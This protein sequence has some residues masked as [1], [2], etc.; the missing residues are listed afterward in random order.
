MPLALEDRLAIT[1]L[2]SLHGHI[3]D[4]GSLERL[5][6]LFTADV[7]HDLTE[8]GQGPLVGVEAIREAALALGAANP[9]AHHVTNI[10]IA[11]SADGLIRVRSKGLGVRADGSCGSVT[12]DDIVIHTPD[13]WRICQRRVSARRTPL[14]GVTQP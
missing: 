8:F 2:V 6:E 13:G 4:D 12:Y 11:E 1:E 7:V 5:E 14:S 9:V 3:V 10:V